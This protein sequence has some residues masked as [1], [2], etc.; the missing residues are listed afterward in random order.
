M[1]KRR[2]RARVEMG[3][4][5]MPL[6]GRAFLALYIRGGLRA[7]YWSESAS[8]EGVTEESVGAVGGP[9]DFGAG[10]HDCT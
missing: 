9:K 8:E 1:V 10:V 3:L 4:H 5:T 6:R 2:A 7:H